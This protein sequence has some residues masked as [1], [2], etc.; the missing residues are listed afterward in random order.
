MS[1]EL[2]YLAQAYKGFGLNEWLRPLVHFGGA[3]HGATLT[4]LMGKH[5]IGNSAES[6]HVALDACVTLGWIKSKGIQPTISQKW[7]NSPGTS[8]RRA[9]LEGDFRDQEIFIALDPEAIEYFVGA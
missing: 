4:E 8:S 6:A 2:C 9:K 3:R 7:G 5:G 1:F